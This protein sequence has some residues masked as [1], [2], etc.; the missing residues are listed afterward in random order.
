MKSRTV[1]AF[2]NVGPRR[3]SADFK[4]LTG[5]LIVSEGTR[6]IEA[7]RPPDSWLALAS[8]NC[9][10]GWGTRPTSH[11]LQTFVNAYALRLTEFEHVAT[12]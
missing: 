7:I 2:T 3:I 11:D 12:S 10:D 4:L 8:L 9:G 1:S 6:I 5:V